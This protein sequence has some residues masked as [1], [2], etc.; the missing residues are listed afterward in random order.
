MKVFDCFSFFNELDLLEIRLNILN[1]VVDYF[2]ICEAEYTH[3]N[4]PKG[5]ILPKYKDRFKQ[6][7][8]KIRYLQFGKEYFKPWSPM[9]PH[10]NE[11]LQRN[12]LVGGLNDLTEQD[13]CLMSDLDEIPNPKTLR[14]IITDN[15][16]P[17]TLTTNLFYGYLN[18]VVKNPTQRYNNGAVVI[19]KKILI[20][21]NYNLQYFRDNKDRFENIPEGGW[22]FSFCVGNN[23]QAAIKKIQSYAHQEFNNT[24]TLQKIEY[25]LLNEKDLLSRSGFERVV[26]NSL[27]P[28]FIKNN[29]TKYK[30]L[31]K[32]S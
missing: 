15:K 17:C 20:E 27:L 13:V 4:E 21:H 8:K 24:A 10:Y 31:L 14:N 9:C 7:G 3:A 16:I 32:Q 1:D 19:N 25:N 2:V 12:A 11:N 5:Y 29:S 18:T 26:D 22:H 28:D 30:H 23:A 6:F